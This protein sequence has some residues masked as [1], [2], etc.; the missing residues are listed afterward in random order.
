M[1]CLKPGD[2]VKTRNPSFEPDLKTRRL[3]G[4]LNRW[5]IEELDNY[6]CE[7]YLVF[8]CPGVDIYLCMSVFGKFEKL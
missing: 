8:D 6:W 5:L 3:E 2:P 1:T 4:N 7:D